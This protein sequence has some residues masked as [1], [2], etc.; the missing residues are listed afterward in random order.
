[1]FPLFFR[2]CS[3]QDQRIGDRDNDQNGEMEQ[4]HFCGKA[5]IICKCAERVDGGMHEDAGDQAPAAVKDSDE[6]KAD[7]DRKDDLAQ[8]ID[9]LLYTSPSPRD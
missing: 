7:R 9:C 6:Q 8:V 3:C 4:V 5:R 2:E 1:M